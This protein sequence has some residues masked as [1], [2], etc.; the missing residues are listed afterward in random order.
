[1]VDILMFLWNYSACGCPGTRV[2]SG[3]SMR[4]GYRSRSWKIVGRLK[5]VGCQ[6]TVSRQK[7]VGCR[8]TS[9]IFYWSFENVF[10]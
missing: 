6:Y 1:M 2:A 4:G 7:I 8:K 9:E 10:F 5:I 3:V